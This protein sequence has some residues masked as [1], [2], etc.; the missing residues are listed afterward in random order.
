MIGTES[1]T[2]TSAFRKSFGCDDDAEGDGD[3]VSHR[4]AFYMGSIHFL[5][6]GQ[7]PRR[8]QVWFE[9]ILQRRSR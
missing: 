5:F 1:D 3:Y 8:R 7:T 2:E 6:V 4:F 9:R